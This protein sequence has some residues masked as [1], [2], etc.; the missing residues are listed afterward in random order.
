M[1]GWKQL[2]VFGQSID[3][4]NLQQLMLKPV[5]GETGGMRAGHNL[6]KNDIATGHDKNWLGPTMSKA[7]EYVSSSGP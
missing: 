1:V 5:R 3:G 4:K 2:S 6:E 7:V